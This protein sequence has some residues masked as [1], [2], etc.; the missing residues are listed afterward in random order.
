VWFVTSGFFVAENP[1]LGRPVLAVSQ[2]GEGVARLAGGW[3]LAAALAG[4][5][6]SAL[7]AVVSRRRATLT[8]TLA[9]AASAAL[10]WFAF[11]E[12]HPFR[13]RYMVPLIAAAAALAAAGIGLLWRPLR[14][15]VA[16]VLLALVL[17][18]APPL[19]P[20]APMLA[21]AQWDTKNSQARRQV[22]RYLTTHDDGQPILVS[23]GSLAHYMQ[24]TSRDGFE[25]RDF[26][27]E[28]NGDLWN[29]ALRV[30]RHH[31][32]WILV[33]ERAEGGDMLF[34]R[35]NADAAFLEG[36]ARVA[37]GGG[38]ALYWRFR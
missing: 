34:Q 17:R 8:V 3:L 21:E 10:P 7:A 9:L 2:V 6:A 14:V 13:I 11:F 16:A 23:M 28:G 38:V 1:A 4:G 20:A 5:A 26:V 12:G 30:P 33:E 32:G 35:A 15:P 27:H 31:V 36:F 18:D 24:E 19:D 22:T 25:I 29:E 37:E